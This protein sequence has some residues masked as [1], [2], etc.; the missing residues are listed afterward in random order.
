MRYVKTDQGYIIRLLKTESV[1]ETLQRF[2]A[3]KGITCAE[4]TGIGAV[5]SATFGYYDLANRKYEFQTMEKML[6]VVSLRGNVA[7]LKE[8]SFLHVHAAFGDSDL[9]VYGGHVKEAVVG[10]TLEVFMT[11]YDVTVARQYDEYSGLNLFGLPCQ[12]QS[13]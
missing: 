7:L 9:K 10:I 6:E 12:F 1:V 3:E 13:A 11:I 4:F 5:S 8:E 2:A